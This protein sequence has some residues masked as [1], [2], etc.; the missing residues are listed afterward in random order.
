MT[1][2]DS[3]TANAH[4]FEAKHFLFPWLA[5]ATGTLAGAIVASLVASARR[6]IAGLV[7]AGAFL[8]GGVMMAL[9]VP[10]PIW[11]L[12]S[13]LGLAYIPMGLLGHKLARAWKP[14]I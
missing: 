5:H 8:G 6:K 11:F 2:I 12:I 13:D 14:G 7:V 3:I 10:A 4:L 1:D 9:S